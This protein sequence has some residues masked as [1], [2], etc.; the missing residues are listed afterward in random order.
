MTELDPRNTPASTEA[1]TRLFAYWLDSPLGGAAEEALYDE[2]EAAWTA[3]PELEIGQDDI[4]GKFRRE[5][6]AYYAGTFPGFAVV[7]EVE[8]AAGPHSLQLRLDETEPAFHIKPILPPRPQLEVMPT[9][10]DYV[11]MPIGEAFDWRKIVS[12][13]K[14]IEPLDDA[15]LYLV[16]FRSKLRHGA[17][18]EA[19]NEHD[20]RAH[21][22]ALE[23]PAL[24]HYFAGLPNSAG[25]ALSFCLWRDVITARE[26]SKDKRHT[27]AMAMVDQYESYSIEKYM[28][29]HADGDILLEAHT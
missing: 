13:A 15:P 28:V 2:A 5:S 10:N 19:L 24:I 3:Y 4:S 21:V 26:I 11:T 14:E 29:H 22:A 25:E 1:V 20:N 12:A 17:D 8:T 6:V 27:D 9:E 18:T 23:S 16:V 7:V